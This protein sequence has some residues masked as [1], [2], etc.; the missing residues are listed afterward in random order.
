MQVQTE[1][2][3]AAVVRETELGV[4]TPPT[5][6]WRN[7]QPN[8][9]GNF[10]PSFKKLPRSPISKKQQLQ[11]GMLVDEDSAVPFQTDITK[12]VIDRFGEGIFRCVAKHG[13][14]TGQS[15]YSPTAVT[16]TG[17]TVPANGAIAA[18]FLILARGFAI[19]DNNGLKL[20]GAG[21]TGVETKTA[22]LVV[23]AAPPA[24][25][26]IEIAGYRGLTGDI[27]L[28]VD[29]NLTST[30]VDFTTWNLHD[31]WWI[32]V[33]GGDATTRF[34]TTA[35][36]GAARI[37]RHGV[38][39]HKIVLDRRSWDVDAFSSLDLAL[40]AANI[41]TVVEAEAVGP[42]R[43]CDPRPHG[44]R[45]R[46]CRQGA[47]GPRDRDDARQHRDPREGRRGRRQCDHRRLH[48]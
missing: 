19:D 46:R 14:N 43:R 45:R 39:A 8:S 27:K 2:T 22:G 17:Y 48:R 33:G 42:G 16:A 13:G 7:L 3:N 4:A 24:N 10:G 5:T 12:D 44:R 26:E 28:D 9:Y 20:V 41:D 34:A 30:T 11:K 23:E 29:G 15:S 37:A 18:R 32:F 21:S 25:C 40:H 35:F 38:T 47:D 1:G 31:Y 6:G 36:H